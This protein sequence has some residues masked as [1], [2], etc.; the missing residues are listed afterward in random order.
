MNYSFIQN[1]PKKKKGEW[2]TFSSFDEIAALISCGAQIT[3]IDRVIERGKTIHY[4][5]L[6]DAAFRVSKAVAEKLI[7]AGH[8][9][10]ITDR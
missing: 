10:S 2:L 3:S 5:M 6:G 8:A 7:A 1:V 4:V 9:E